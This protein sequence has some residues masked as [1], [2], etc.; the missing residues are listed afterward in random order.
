MTSYSSKELIA[1]IESMDI[2]Y[3]NW[4]IGITARPNARKAEHGNPRG[5]IIW[6][7]NSLQAAKNTE[8]H[9][10]GLGMDGGGGGDMDEKDT[11]YVYIF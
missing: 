8:N 3:S 2:T 1:K 5:W 7:A 6:Q 10:I 4:T 11:T 9:F